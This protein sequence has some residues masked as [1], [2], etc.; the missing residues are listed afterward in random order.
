MHSIIDR[1]RDLAKEKGVFEENI[2]I[3]LIDKLY[4]EIEKENVSNADDFL[5]YIHLHLDRKYPF[6]I[7]KVKEWK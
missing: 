7:I 1:I 6:E 4:K 2:V 5:C 3:E